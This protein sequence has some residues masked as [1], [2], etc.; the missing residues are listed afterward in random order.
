ME[1][2]K[3]PPVLVH[4]DLHVQNIVFKKS[5]AEIDLVGLLDWQVRYNQNSASWLQ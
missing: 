5:D 3:L 2:P 1:E 4:G